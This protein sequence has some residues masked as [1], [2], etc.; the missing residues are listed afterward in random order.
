M[1][2]NFPIA[3]FDAP[4]I[5]NCG[6]TPIPGSGSSPLQVIADSGFRSGVAIDYIDTT[7]DFIG[8]YLGASGLET[9][10]CIIGNGLASRA[11]AKDAYLRILVVTSACSVTAFGS[12]LGTSAGSTADIWLSRVAQG[13]IVYGA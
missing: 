12:N 2:Y 5:V 13:S 8:V 9:L 10:L 1:N 6:V 3:F 11:W 4:A 7:G